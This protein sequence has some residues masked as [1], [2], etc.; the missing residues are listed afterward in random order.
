MISCHQSY[1]I[2]RRMA[3]VRGPSHF[4]TLFEDTLCHRASWDSIHR[5]FSTRNGFLH[6]SA[7]FAFDRGAFWQTARWRQKC[8]RFWFFMTTLP[9]VCGWGCAVRRANFYI[10]VNTQYMDLVF[11]FNFV[12]LIAFEIRCRS[13]FC[14][15]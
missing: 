11:L 15:V 2:T 5:P 8:V 6:H 10:F 12:P 7:P 9:A 13:L 4:V 3:T 14:E 1:W